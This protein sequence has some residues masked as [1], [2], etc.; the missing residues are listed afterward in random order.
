[1]VKPVVVDV[2]CLQEAI[3][4]LLGRPTIPI[5]IVRLLQLEVGAE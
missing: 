2:V 5:R 4:S 1:M 3:R